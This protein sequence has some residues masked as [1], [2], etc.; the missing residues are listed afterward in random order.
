MAYLIDGEEVQVVERIASGVVIRRIYYKH[1]D[2]ECLAPPEIVEQVFDEPPTQKKAPEIFALERKE[3]EL[4]TRIAGHQR[5]IQQLA[6]AE[7]RVRKLH[8]ALARIDDFMSARITHYLVKPAWGRLKI[9]EAVKGAFPDFDDRGRHSGETKLLCL[10]GKSGGDLEWK[11]NQ[12]YDGSGT[13]TSVEPFASREDVLARLQEI[14]NGYESDRDGNLDNL[15]ESAV[16]HGLRVPDGL[17]S[18][19]AKRKLAA[20]EGVV[21]DTQTALVKAQANLTVAREKWLRNA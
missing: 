20:A 19:I 7:A 5:Q 18:L 4:R 13:W 11:V 12:Y 1:D 21:T 6:E 14:V 10:F 17:H 3:E 15:Y 16:E 9:V 8:P 2:E